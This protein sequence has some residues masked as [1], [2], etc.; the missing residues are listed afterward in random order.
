ME[1]SH[2]RPRVSRETRL[3][4]TTGVLAVAALWVLARIRFPELPAA[5]SPVPSVL[6]QLASGP[7]YDDLA[8]Q[9]AQAQTRLDPFLLALDMPPAARGPLQPPRRIVALRL[10]DDLAVTLLPAWPNVLA[11]DGISV[12]ATDRASGLTVVRVA[13]QPPPA[14]PVPWT[15]RRARQP[16]YLIATD[17]SPLGV[18]LRPAF[19]GSLDPAESP[20]W[21]EPLWAVPAQSGLVRGSFLFTDAAEL[22]GLAIEHGSGLAI[23]P[24]GTLLADVERL[25]ERPSGPA[26]AIGVEVQPLT[27]ALSAVTGASVGVVVTWIDMEGAANGMLRAGDVIEAVDG[28]ALVTRDEWDARM[29]RL[30]AGDRLTLGVRS[31]GE[32]REVVLVASAPAAQPAARP[33]GLTLRGRPGIGSEVVRVERVSAADL[34]GLTAGDLITL[35]GEIA[36]PTPAQIARSFSSMPQGQRVIIAVTRADTHHVLTLDR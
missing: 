34:A 29:A 9:I 27:P 4:L 2:Y 19:V 10:R 17:V 30:S 7:Q 32:V 14:P 22:V 35:I 24:G 18:S 1:F 23:V 15:L 36:A 31:R 11:P 13:G 6:S 21:A 33:L 5:P 3:L 28:R 26:G 20:Q 16:R 12:Q 25:L 8:S